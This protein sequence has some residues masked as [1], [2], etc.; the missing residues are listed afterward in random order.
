MIQIQC[1]QFLSDKIRKQKSS[2]LLYK[3]LFFRH[4]SGSTLDL[5]IYTDQ[6][7]MY[8]DILIYNRSAIDLG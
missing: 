4:R 1:I 8:A 5:K 2:I 3:P 6:L 7:L